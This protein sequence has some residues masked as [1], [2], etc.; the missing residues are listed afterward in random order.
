MPARATRFSVNAHA[1]E[2]ELPI[3][4]RVVPG[5][6]SDGA[7]G[8]SPRVCVRAFGGLV[9]PVLAVPG[10]KLA[11]AVA[12][13]AFAER[14]RDFAGPTTD[15]ARVKIAMASTT[16]SHHEP[17]RPGCVPAAPARETPAQP[18]ASCRDR[19]VSPCSF[20]RSAIAIVSILR[21]GP[22]SSAHVS[23]GLLPPARC[24]LASGLVLSLRLDDRP[25]TWR[26]A[27]DSPVLCCKFPEDHLKA[28]RR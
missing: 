19:Y 16:V 17:S 4:S 20:P 24:R 26:A 22:D 10:A 14:V 1:P 8:W 15:R 5:G 23:R 12:L 6:F 27:E 13:R 21:A 11:R 28:S 3:L 7:M 25:Q 2:G 9:V 18:S